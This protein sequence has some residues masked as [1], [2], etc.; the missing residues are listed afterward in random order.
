MNRLLFSLSVRKQ[1]MISSED[2]CADGPISVFADLQLPKQA[3]LR[4]RRFDD[5]T[6]RNVLKH[7]PPSTGQKSKA[8]KRGFIAESIGFSLSVNYKT[9]Y[10]AE[11]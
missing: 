4:H 11:S 6:D 10:K 1:G 2:A 3:Q 5:Q 9:S 7:V 8:Q